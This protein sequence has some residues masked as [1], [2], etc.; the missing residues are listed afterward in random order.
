M[1]EH[2]AAAAVKGII[3]T[4]SQPFDIGTVRVVG[5]GLAVVSGIAAQPISIGRAG[6]SSI[7][8]AQVAAGGVDGKRVTVFYVDRQPQILTTMEDI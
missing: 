2:R 1:S 3:G 6:W 8:G 4:P 7:F 5:G